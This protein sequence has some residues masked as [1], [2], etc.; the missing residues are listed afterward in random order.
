M[1]KRSVMKS[2]ALYDETAIAE[3]TLLQ[4]N[5]GW[6][7]ENSIDWK[8]PIDLNKLLVPLDENALFFPGASSEQRL[9]I[10]QMMGLII[11][12]SICEME[13][14]LVRIKGLAF[15]KILEK[16][17]VSPEFIEL[18]E[19]FFEEENKHSKVFRRYLQKFSESANIELS[20]LK[21][22]LPFVENT[23][24]EKILR[25]NLEKGG[26]AFWWIVAEVEHEFLHLYHAIAPFKDKVDPLYYILHKKHFEEEARH[27]PFPY[28]MLELLMTREQGP[29]QYLR[30]KSDL[31]SS[32]ILQTIWTGNSLTKMKTMKK[33]ATKHPFFQTFCSALPL[34]EKQPPWSILWKFL[35]SAP[36]VSS[37]VN[38]RSHA[39]FLKFSKK[40]GILSFPFPSP[41][42]AI[43]VD[44]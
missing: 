31:I 16:H 41:E 44:Y 24:T 35:T 2:I 30:V 6:D 20:E 40:H 22:I 34:F 28:L 29:I 18:G 7:L 42:P 23:L 32:Q 5:K 9:V 14:C 25:K 27:A 8:T 26:T 1:Q 43:L 4:K 3:L 33:F 17:P 36:Y 38:P 15:E 37:L 21:S 12:A 13:E 39:P 11:A 19:Q 10:S